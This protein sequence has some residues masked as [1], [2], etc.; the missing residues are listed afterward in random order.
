MNELAHYKDYDPR[1]ET[2]SSDDDDSED[3]GGDVVSVGDSESDGIGNDDD[4]ASTD[5]MDDV[6]G[7]G[8]KNTEKGLDG[9]YWKVKGRRL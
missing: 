6:L 9:S 4:D 2:V 7:V 8:W 5:E 1:S 3:D